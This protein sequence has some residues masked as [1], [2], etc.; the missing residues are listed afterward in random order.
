MPVGGQIGNKNAEKWTEEKATDLGNELLA[1]LMEDIELTDVD[2]PEEC[3]VK[4][5]KR[6]SDNIFWE[7]F[8]IIHNN[9]SRNIINYLCNKFES[10]RETI[11]KANEIQELKLRKGGLDG[12]F[13]RSNVIFLQKALFGVT[14]N[15]FKPKYD[16]QDTEREADLTHLTTNTT[17]VTSVYLKNIEA[18]EKGKRIILNRG[19]SR[20]SKTYSL[21]QIFIDYLFTGKIGNR[22]IQG[23]VGVFRKSL[24]YLKKNLLE[25]ILD[26]FANKDISI[27]YDIE[28][29]KSECYFQHQNRK[30]FYGSLN[31]EAE[32]LKVRGMGLG[33]IWFNE[34]P[35]IKYE[36][37][38]Q[39]NMRAKE[40]AAFFLDFNPDEENSWV[41]EEIEK[42]RAEKIGDV[43]LIH[44]TYND[45]RFLPESTIKEI[46][47]FK[48]T[49]PDYF[50]I[51]GKGLYGK[52]RGLI[53]PTWQEYT[54]LPR[55]RYITWFGQD[56]G[57]SNSKDAVL[58]INWKR[59]S[60]DIYIKSHLY[61]TGLL[62]S[63]LT[64]R[65][66]KIV[67]DA[68]VFADCEDART[69]G[70]ERKAGINVIKPKKGK[71]RGINLVQCY[72]IYI[73][74]DDIDT[75]KEIKNYRWKKDPNNDDKFLNVP[76]E[77]HSIHEHLI[78]CLEY[79]IIGAVDTNL[80]PTPTKMKK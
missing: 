18:I 53:Y 33:A 41:N 57:Y 37:F 58:E 74:A 49:D 62:A 64:K 12:T 26:I 71:M 68:T 72:N 51:Y 35:E 70:D 73:H 65:V 69:I 40:N 1:W 44:S 78:K 55:A 48:L 75:Q 28:W 79:G 16:W 4:L 67:D 66:K 43:A 76:M 42:K 17:E 23:N 8:L 21:C 34:A 13:D 31:N 36:A 60:K 15:H 47:N 56:F 59:N 22:E 63:D 30:W 38:K 29:N 52:L 10:F 24:P 32:I 27:G 19:G 9:L 3:E 20:S 5:P 7:D 46:E 77:G 45:N 50:N 61:K 11:K 80:I 39:L 25:D 54:E 14:E 6:P 2:N